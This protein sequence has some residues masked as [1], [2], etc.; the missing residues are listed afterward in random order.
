M[1][2]RGGLNYCL[3]I[4]VLHGWSSIN[5]LHTGCIPQG[6]RLRLR[7]PL[8]LNVIREITNFYWPLGVFDRFPGLVV[9]LGHIGE[10]VPYWM[11][12]ASSV[13][14]RGREVALREVWAR[15]VYV[16]T[17]GIW[18]LDPMWSSLAVTDV[19]RVMYSV[20]WLLARNEDGK[21]FMGELRSSRLVTEAQWKG[22]AAG[23]A[24][25]L[26]KL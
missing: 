6:G 4:F 11:W 20:D 10:M 7:Y 8:T 21:V 14:G 5:A 17:S 16:T 3:L 12:R 25:R 26:L 19:S 18:S 24:K 9:V 2:V 22:I 1:Y 23:N 15:N 13:L